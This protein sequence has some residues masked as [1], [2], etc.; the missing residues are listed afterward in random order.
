M[1]EPT[2]PAH[3]TPDAGRLTP[4][5]IPD[6]PRVL[7]T[8]A[9]GYIGGRLVPELL[10][11][12]ARVRVTGRHADSLKAWD[13]SDRTEIVEADLSDRMAVRRAVED[14]DVI[15]FLVHAMGGGKGY[16]DREARMARI[17][18]DEA[19]RAH[20]GRIVYLSGIHPEHEELSEH[21][22]SREQ[23]AR[24]LREGATPVVVVQ[25]ATVIGA[26]SASFEIIRHLSERLPVMP[27][28]RWVDN[29][30]EPV[31]IGDVLHYL[32]EA[33]L[34]RDDIAGT[35]DIGCGEVLRFR[36]LLTRYAE[37]AGL[38]RRRVL[39]LP[40]PVPLLSGAWIGLIT[41]IPIR[42]A[43]PLA[44]S[45]QHEAVPHDR[46][47][48]DVLA[49]PEHGPTSYDDA[50][51]AALTAQKAGTLASTWDNDDSM[52]A[53]PAAPLP[54]DPDWAG[55]TVFT[56]DRERTDPE[57]RPE[58]VWA[59]IEGIGGANGWYSTPLLW[60]ARGVMDRLLGGY[61]LARGRRDA[62][63]LRVGDALDW[64]RVEAIDPGRSLTLRAEMRM[65]GRAWLQLTV[66]PAEGGGSSYHQRAV[67]F[68]DGLIGRLY[69]WG[70]FPFHA[71]VFPSMARHILR[72]AREG[73]AK[74]RGRRRA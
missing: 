10:E 29:R 14:V 48:S 63:H 16:A 72:A 47:L 5:E 32:T 27:A 33:A 9:S 30:I 54:P 19:A 73:G 34:A 21:M 2:T 39:S 28:P 57:A 41:P 58:A 4:P 46:P 44:Q 20:V 45:M 66:E 23:V 60:R 71:L 70:I 7:V 74:R 43:L 25:A 64:W 67:Y 49:P 12:G 35:Y 22:A 15:V 62:K 68:P 1:P 6:H 56:D 38:P 31:A 55:H 24:I 53:D 65:S 3:A 11:A 50:V 13:W 26:G 8:G 17:V 40:V 42:T 59:V 36:D 61:G 52:D 18:A 37:V 51:R 69:W